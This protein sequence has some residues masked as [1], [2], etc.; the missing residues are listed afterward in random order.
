MKNKIL[1]EWLGRLKENA[2]LNTLKTTLSP[3]LDELRNFHFSFFNPL[4]WLFFLILLLVLT[5]AWG[6]KKSFSLC[7]I[8]AAV[9]LATTF[10]EQ[11]M[12]ETFGIT[13]VLL[14]RLICFFVLALI[15]VYYF[16]IRNE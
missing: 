14:I 5:K 1:Q 11:F 6:I 13:D 16:F 7:S 10:V 12:I 2:Y 3:Y 4:F 8:V 15:F 9:L